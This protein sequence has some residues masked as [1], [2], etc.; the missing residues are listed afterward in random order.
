MVDRMAT[1]VT[2]ARLARLKERV[3]AIERRTEPMGGGAAEP[4]LWGDVRPLWGALNEVR[5]ADW[6]DAPAALGFAIAL[7]LLRLKRR[8]APLL[9]IE[10]RSAEPD[11]SLSACGLLALGGD[12]ASALFI[13]PRTDNEALLAA[14]RASAVAGAVVI[15]FARGRFANASLA[16]TRR[17]SLAASASGATP[18]IVRAGSA[19]PPCAAAIR[20]LVAPAPSRSAP[21]NARAPGAPAFRVS[22]ARGP[23]ISSR[24]HSVEWRDDEL[25]FAECGGAAAPAADSGAGLSAD[26]RRSLP[27]PQRDCAIGSLRAS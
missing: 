26:R 22:L 10:A 21:F 13:R 25:R 3:R 18:I 24:I 16:A 17:I 20:F 19:L 11:G 6:R 23:D 9:L 27:P 8:P 12:P 7:A 4:P 1:Q 2:R 5:G 14:E 15:A